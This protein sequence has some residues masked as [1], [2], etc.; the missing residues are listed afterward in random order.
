MYMPKLSLLM[1]NF[2]RT[3]FFKVLKMNNSSIFITNFMPIDERKY[4]V[5]SFIKFKVFDYV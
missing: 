4:K 5:V 2:C 1:C 3:T